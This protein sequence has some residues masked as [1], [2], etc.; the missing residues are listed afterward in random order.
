MLA[1]VRLLLLCSLAALS[2]SANAQQSPSPPKT[3]PSP[4]KKQF[5]QELAQYNTNRESLRAQ[6]EQ[7]FDAEMARKRWETA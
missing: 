4:A 2:F 3:S 1:N 6:A 7:A 5:L